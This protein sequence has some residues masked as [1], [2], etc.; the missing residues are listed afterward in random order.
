[1]KKTIHILIS[2]CVTCAFLY[3]VF[4]EQTF[5]GFLDIIKSVHTGYLSWYILLVVIGIVARSVRYRIVFLIDEGAKSLSWIQTLVI[6]LVRNALV[7][8]LPA[9]LGEFGFFYIAKRY[10]VSIATTTTAFG[11][12]LALDI[13]V[14]G[15]I[16]VLAIA[17]APVFQSDA[18]LSDN[19][20]PVLLLF[21]SLGVVTT[22]LYNMDRVIAFFTRF[23]PSGGDKN[24]LQRFLKLG[25]EFVITLGT[26]ATGLKADRKF[27]HLILSTIVLRVAK[28]SGLY[29]LLVAVISQWEFG[30]A[31]LNPIISFA[32]FISAEASASL[33]VSGI[34]GFGAYE[35]AW[36]AI[37]SLSE[38]EIPSQKS[39]IF[40]HHL[41]TQIVGYS[42]GFCGLLWFFGSELL[43]KEERS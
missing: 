14:L 20:L 26:Q 34:M 8:F 5:D 43:S 40:A 15:Y 23:L 32:A 7:D 13:V 11:L 29:V 10:G 4:K 22:F 18:V 9:R 42:F 19:L 3:V 24:K 27:F 6:T 16:V 35:S 12:C 25:K 1:M 36:V 2:A 21:V 28:Y 31:D 17:F 38:V 39:V 41:I 37:F 30:F 33:P